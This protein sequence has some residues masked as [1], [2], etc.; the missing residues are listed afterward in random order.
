MRNNGRYGTIPSNKE[1]ILSGMKRVF[2]SPDGVAL[3]FTLGS[4]VQLKSGG[5]PM[6][7]HNLKHDTHVGT[8]WL[9]TDGKVE[10]Q[11][12]APDILMVVDTAQEAGGDAARAG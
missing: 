9:S 7:V 6:T 5:L 4:V 12:F 11:Y 2:H 1:D 10:E 3:E 8:T